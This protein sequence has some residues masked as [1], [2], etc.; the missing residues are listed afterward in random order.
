[1]N[2]FMF[3]RDE[4]DGA[5]LSK[6]NKIKHSG[7]TGRYILG[8]KST[9]VNQSYKVCK[10]QRERWRDDHAGGHPKKEK[11]SNETGEVTKTKRQ[12]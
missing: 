4:N 11:V 7:T 3:R 1:M 12:S 2:V 9:T 5:K 6:R 10:K 8:W